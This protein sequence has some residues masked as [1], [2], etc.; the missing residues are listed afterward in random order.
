MLYVLSYSH[1]LL[2][3]IDFIINNKNTS[4]KV[5]IKM[6]LCSECGNYENNEICHNAIINNRLD[7]LKYVHENGY[8]WDESTCANAALND[9]LTML[10]YAH[11]NGCP[12][13]GITCVK[14]ARNGHLGCLKYAHENGCPWH[15]YVCTYAAHHNHFIVSNTHMRMGVLVI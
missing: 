7:C 2:L 15:E 6:S 10:K 14:A 8:W 1:F 3:K 12:W 4:I 11:E 13:D 5:H 9:N